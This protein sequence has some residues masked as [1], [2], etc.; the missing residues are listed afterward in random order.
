M[1]AKLLELRDKM[2]FIPLLAVELTGENGDQMYLLARAGYGLIRRHVILTALRAE[3][4]AHCDPYAWN[5]RT[6][7]VAHDFIIKNWETLSDGDVIDVEF[8]LGETK[9]KKLSE[10]YE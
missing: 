6:F 5:D 7:S 3:R 8:I 2:T 4:I 10:R 9:T 1:T